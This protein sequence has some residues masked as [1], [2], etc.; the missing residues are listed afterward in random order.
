MPI[1]ACIFDAYGTLFDVTAAARA[2]AAEFPHSTIT[3]DWPALAATWRDKQLAYT[4]LRATSGDHTDFW[5]VTQNALDY[6]LEAH[7]LNG[8]ATLRERLL[9][10]YW[11]LEAYSEVP[12]MLA[13]LKAEG[14]RTAILS[15]G[16]PDMLGAAVSSAQ[17]QISFDALF[18]VEDVGVFK[19]SPAVYALPE[20][21][22]GLHASDMLFVSS[23]GWDAACAARYGYQTV[24]VNRT[25]LPPERLG[26]RADHEVKD[27]TALPE[28]VRR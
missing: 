8:D 3:Q 24:W 15:N 7:S 12:E 13:Q 5:T 6:A 11:Q 28:L 2:A 14:Q 19:P 1:K 20:K 27:L 16:S 21:A 23:N 4:W 26:R 10:L 22:F 25:A 17:L 18:S 9:Q